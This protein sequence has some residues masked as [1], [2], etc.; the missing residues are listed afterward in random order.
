MKVEVP[1]NAW[2]GDDILLLDFPDSWELATAR[3]RDAQALKDEQIRQA[4]EDPIGTGR[5]SEMA[6]GHRKAA[7]IVDDL[8][9]PTPASKLMPKVLEELEE[10]GIPHRHVT[11]VLATGAHRPM[12]KEDMVKKL[13][14]V[15]LEKVEVLNHN[16]YEPL[17]SLGRTSFGTPIQV[18]RF[19]MECDYKIGVGGIYPHEA[20]FGGFGGGAKLVV[21]GIA[22]MDSIDHN[23]RLQGFGA[24]RKDAEEAARKIGLNIIVNVVVNS[25]REICGVFV[26]DLVEAHNIGVEF[27]RKVYEVSFPKNAD[28]A[29]VNSYP[30]DTDLGQ[31]MRALWIGCKAV[32]KG[33]TIVLSASCPEGR[34]YHALYGKGGRHWKPPEGQMEAGGR[35][36]LFSPNVS[37]K[38]AYGIWPEGALVYNTWQEAKEEVERIHGSKAKVVVFPNGTTSITFQ[39]P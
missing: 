14:R 25:R 12:L 11:V 8:T 6:K 33:G 30:M 4:F 7:V 24:Q 15:V 26:G 28:V 20:G 10:G 31:A 38:E 17:V 3:I 18:C 1:F 9:R 36:I 37:P 34:G 21:P 13:G 39:D 35:L 22:G 5:L 16:P 32:E 19:V 23:H 27:A 29:V 2:Y